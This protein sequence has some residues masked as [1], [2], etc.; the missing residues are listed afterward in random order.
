V[1]E[2]SISRSSMRKAQPR[3]DVIDGPPKPS[4]TIRRLR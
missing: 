4:R 3:C 2:F 1:R